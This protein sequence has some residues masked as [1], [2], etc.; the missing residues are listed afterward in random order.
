MRQSAGS[1]S[2]MIVQLDSQV[3]GPRD[4]SRQFTAYHVAAGHSLSIPQPRFPTI[5]KL[6]VHKTRGSV[7]ATRDLGCGLTS[8]GGVLSEL[9]KA[10]LVRYTR[11]RSVCTS[12]DGPTL[13]F[14]RHTR[15]LDS[16]GEV[17]ILRSHEP[18]STKLHWVGFEPGGAQGQCGCSA[19]GGNESR[20][21]L[22]RAPPSGPK[23]DRKAL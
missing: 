14:P 17:S 12:E 1:I 10:R 16:R 9:N 22:S 3:E 18:S 6:H 21:G 8:R 13:R 4:N 15:Q 7:S 23:E 5:N 11:A 2:L 20:L 19:H